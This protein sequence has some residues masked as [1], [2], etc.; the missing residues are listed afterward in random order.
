MTAVERK[1][2]IATWDGDARSW[3]DY[4]K[5]VRLQFERTEYHK[6]RFLG[7]ELA[8]R[9]TGRAWDV[10]SADI[11]HRQL[12]Q[13]EG[14]AY[15]LR[16]LEDRLCKTP[17]PDL[18]QRLEEFFLKLRR[19]PGSSMT[20]WATALRESYRRLQRAMAR[21][22]K[23]TQTT[24]AT[25]SAGVGA[26]G[27][28]SSMSPESLRRRRSDITSPQAR[29]AQETFANFP[30]EEVLSNPGHG[31]PATNPGAEHEPTR[32][33]YERIPTS[34][35][36]AWSDQRWTAEEW[37]QWRQRHWQCG[38]DD[39]YDQPGATTIEWDQFDHGELQILPEEILGWLLLRRSNLPAPARLSVLS[40]INNKLDLDSMERA[41]RD[42]EEELLLSESH[43]HQNLP[44]PKRTF[45]VEQ[46]S[47]WG[48]LNDQDVDD[49]DDTRVCWVG[50]RLPPEIYPVWEESMETA[51]S[52]WTPD[53][54]ELQWQWMDDDFYAQDMD[55]V[56]WS[57]TETR[58]WQDVEACALS[59]PQ[60]SEEILSVYAAFQDKMRTFRESRQLNHAKQ[61]SRGFYPL[62][63]IKGKS[64]GK[65]SSSKG[66]KGKGKG[67]SSNKG[68]SA[69]ANF[70]KGKGTSSSSG[71]QRPGQSGYTGCFICG[72]HEHDFRS[73]PKR[74]A[75]Q[76]S[77]AHVASST[78]Y[79]VTA[80]DEDEEPESL[81]VLTSVPLASALSAT[82][83]D[84]PG[85]AIIDLGATE[86]LA[87]LGALEE[88]MNLRM[89]KFGHEPVNVRDEHR[90]F[91]F[92]NGQC[93]RAASFV[94]IPQL[95]D[96]KTITL[97]V[98][99][100]DAAGV[101]LLLSVRTLRRMGAVIDT[102]R[103]CMKLKKFSEKWIPLKQGANE[104]LLLDLTSDWY[105]QETVHETFTAGSAYKEPADQSPSL[106]A[107]VPQGN[108]EQQ[109]VLCSSPFF[110]SSKPLSAE[111]QCSRSLTKPI[112]ALEVMSDEEMISDE[113][114][115]KE[116][117]PHGLEADTPFQ[118][119]Q[120]R[121]CS[122]SS[123]KLNPTA[124]VAL[125]SATLASSLAYSH[126]DC[127]IPRKSDFTSHPDN[128]DG[129][130]G[131]GDL[132]NY[133][134]QSEGHKEPRVECG[135]VRPGESNR[136]RSSRS[137][138]QCLPLLRPTCSNEGGK[139]LALRGERTCP[140][141]MLRSV[142]VEN[143]VHSHSWL[144][145]SS[146]S[147]R[148]FATGCVPGSDQDECRATSARTQKPRDTQ[149][150]DRGCAGRR[151]FSAQ[152]VGEAGEREV[153]DQGQ[154]SS[155]IDGF[156]SRQS[157]DATTTSEG[158]HGDA[159]NEKV[160]QEGQWRQQR[161]QRQHGQW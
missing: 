12:Q 159:W 31:E 136:T 154:G 37:W 68:P 91:K 79:V 76:S 129:I 111:M 109:Q 52:T 35:P 153:Q 123:M 156:H 147:S 17:I 15:L 9:L 57:W 142:Q 82:N 101:P 69:F 160:H 104:H 47:Q 45:W 103:N 110:T 32:E 56:F 96:G 86:T 114:Y 23:Q 70:Q 112:A 125:A 48:L 122:G 49:V 130:Y 67:T 60:D 18:G 113:V 94:E 161:K 10:T 29:P 100:L 149:H 20:E 38:Q 54:Y 143:P 84:Y 87:S 11:D 117:Q 89:R 141:G 71:L 78:I 131:R 137:K 6:R 98:H 2:Q 75:E 24:S 22:R 140:L 5:R 44:R 14:C 135:Q 1:E 127:G 92:G 39:A 88:L 53:G 138:M 133:E 157:Y 81:Q 90:R 59:A 41:M 72:S 27:N 80:V 134:G 26:S 66:L 126:G 85:H 61:Q 97:G 77:S 46:D 99:A 155:F 63:M 144:D 55:G 115:Q 16:F 3:T 83:T 128:V 106:I 139:V 58:D 146:P 21:Q 151:G 43:R 120:Q 33:N 51:W 34:E 28:P 7:P 13:P 118:C 107:V 19:T 73:C 145:G 42:Q 132:G 95:I 158:D 74:R 108:L 25:A 116:V 62:G 93:Q 40:A 102:E 64:K 119:A 30:D 148:T 121:G 150:Q 65:S 105:H 124:I 4:V 50:D 36:D 8:S 152:E